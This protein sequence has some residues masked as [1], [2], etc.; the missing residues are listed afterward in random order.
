MGI[1]FLRMVR[2][3]PLRAMGHLLNVY[4]DQLWLELVQL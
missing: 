2:S 3:F 4:D 1:R